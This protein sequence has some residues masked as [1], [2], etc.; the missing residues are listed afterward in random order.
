MQFPLDLSDRITLTDIVNDLAHLERRS[1][2]LDLDFLA[3]LIS[4]ALEE[5]C[6]RLQDDILTKRERLGRNPV[7]FGSAVRKPAAK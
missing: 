6:D 1:V 4:H 5:A 7:D 3:L 2:D